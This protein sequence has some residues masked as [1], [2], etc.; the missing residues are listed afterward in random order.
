MR[1]GYGI[2][3]LARVLETTPPDAPVEAWRERISLELRQ[4][5]MD[6][7]AE[8][9]QICLASINAV[10]AGINLGRYTNSSRQAVADYERYWLAP[11]TQVNEAAQ[12]LARRAALP[13]SALD[14][15]SAE[16]L[17][18]KA[19]LQSWSV[20]Q[21]VA[22]IDGPL[23]SPTS[24]TDP[25][26]IIERARQT[27]RRAAAISP[28]QPSPTAPITDD[29]DDD[30]DPQAAEQLVRDALANTANFFLG[31]IEDLWS[32]AE[33]TAFSN[34]VNVRVKKTCDELREPLNVIK[35]NP[36]LLT[37]TETRQEL[38]EAEIRIQAL[39]QDINNASRQI[40]LD[41][42]FI[43]AL[44]TALKNEALV[45]GK[46]TGGTI[47]CPVA[48]DQWQ[49]IS[50]SFHQRWLPNAR[51]I[52]VNNVTIELQP[53]Q[54]LALYVTGSS[55]SGYAFDVSVHLWRRRPDCQ[56]LPSEKTGAYP[57][58][59]TADWFDTYQTCCV[60]HVPHA[61]QN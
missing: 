44:G 32:M 48:Y 1:N 35:K 11:R 5:E 31:E 45:L 40:A 20:D 51:R 4:A 60:L 18:D 61:R 52:L 37:E 30:L 41:R 43:Q 23:S 17:I 58:I 42:H 22:W 53:D 16:G 3:A 47:A 7:V 49:A 28:S 10:S 57:P 29:T 39:R 59:N 2:N 19:S 21:L 56:S 38:H 54:A 9:M 34:E 24:N 6:S 27:R 26:Q 14:A 55:Q 33:Q 36:K 46:K 12:R 25:K 8:D 15:G 13:A 50:D